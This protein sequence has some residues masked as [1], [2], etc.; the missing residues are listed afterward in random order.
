MEGHEQDFE[1]KQSGESSSWCPGGF[2]SHSAAQQ[3]PVSS[4]EQ[5]HHRLTWGLGKEPKERRM[6]QTSFEESGYYFRNSSYHP[7]HADTPAASSPAEKGLWLTLKAG[8]SP[9]WLQESTRLAVTLFFSKHSPASFSKYSPWAGLR[10]F[11]RDFVT[12]IP[13]QLHHPPGGGIINRSFS[14]LLSINEETA[15]KYWHV[16]AHNWVDGWVKIKN[17]LC[18]KLKSVLLIFSPNSHKNWKP[19]TAMH[20][21]AHMCT[22]DT[23]EFCQQESSLQADARWDS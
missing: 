18:L 21:P 20:L 5:F 8:G 7:T 11:C 2:C 17:W 4:K 15:V 6:K 9:C 14:H 19:E 10:E 23:C 3:A 22:S 12:M 13:F 1:L 16:K